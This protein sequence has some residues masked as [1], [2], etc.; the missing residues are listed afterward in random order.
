MTEL[1]SILLIG[2]S[3]S[4][5]TFSLSLSMGS[6]IK[7]NKYLNV[8]PFLV[9]LFHFFMPLVGNLI[10]IEVLNYFN[11]ASE[12][13]LGL[14][15]VIIGI[16][17]AFNYL[18]KEE[19]NI[20]LNYISIIFLSFSVSIDSFTVGF[21]ISNIVSN[22]ILASFIFSVCSFFFT[23]LGLLVGKYSSKFIGK[24]ASFVGIALL[25]LLGIF[26]IL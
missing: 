13:V 1:I 16:N 23:T 24:Y 7:N 25:I 20:N 8:F 17:F 2:V 26:H 3:L 11:L 10:G 9:S 14:V 4:M 19:I 18:K 5:D 15:L 12:K 21:A 6:L 22:F